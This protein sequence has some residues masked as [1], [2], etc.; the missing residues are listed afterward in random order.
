MSKLNKNHLGSYRRNT[1]SKSEYFMEIAK[2]TSKRSP[3][4]NTQVGAC[5]E[6]KG[7]LISVGFNC[8]P[9][10]WDYRLFPFENDT[11]T[12][13]YENT[14]YPYINHAEYNA[15]LNSSNSSKLK[16][17]TAFV[18][19]FPC[20]E[21]AKALAAC[22]IKRVV[23]LDRRYPNTEIDPSEETFENCNIETINYKDYIK[24]KIL[25]KKKDED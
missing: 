4:P 16:G 2:I 12:L 14:K 1:I 19:L 24:R 20:P 21:C 11:K 8:P 9:E 13:G 5:I 6:K 17:S 3:D 22:K 10:G 23:Y 25:K 15:I 18:T 7:K